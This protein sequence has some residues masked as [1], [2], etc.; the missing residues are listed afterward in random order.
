MNEI[1]A[2]IPAYPQLSTPMAN[3]LQ[4]PEK[5]L[6]KRRYPQPLDVE[7]PKHRPGVI[8]SDC[9]V[10]GYDNQGRPQLAKI[11]PGAVSNVEVVV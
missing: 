7:M 10:I 8:P 9:R 11:P 3:E 1:N 6:P 5:I 4:K 2:I